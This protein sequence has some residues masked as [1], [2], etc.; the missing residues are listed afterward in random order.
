[1]KNILSLLGKRTLK[2]Y[3]YFNVVFKDRL[4][5]DDGVINGINQLGNKQYSYD[6]RDDNLCFNLDWY[7]KTNHVSDKMVSRQLYEPITQNEFVRRKI[8]TCEWHNKWLDFDKIDIEMQQIN[9]CE[10][11][12]IQALHDFMTEQRKK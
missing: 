6:T 10:N 8:I 1:M 7:D 3:A 9:R 11:Q 4:C 5:P 2:D 12:R